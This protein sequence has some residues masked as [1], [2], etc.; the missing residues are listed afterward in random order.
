MEAALISMSVLALVLFRMTTQDRKASRNS[1][2]TASRDSRVNQR[3]ET[4]VS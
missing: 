3:K 1:Q 2:L 4:N